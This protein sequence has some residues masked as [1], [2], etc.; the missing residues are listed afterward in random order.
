MQLGIIT[1]WEFLFLSLYKTPP[2]YNIFMNIRPAI[3]ELLLSDRNYDINGGSFANCL[4]KRISN[5][6]SGLYSA[7]GLSEYLLLVA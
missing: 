2:P 1:R 7:W 6:E 5:Y 3:P 4:C